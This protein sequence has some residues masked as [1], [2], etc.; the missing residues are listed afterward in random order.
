MSTA[1]KNY[2]KF[3]PKGEDSF[4]DAVKYRV[5]EY[6]R[7][8][9]ITEH[10][11]TAM[12]LKTVAMLSLYIV[13]YLLI[14]TGV[15]SVNTWLFMGLWVLMG[16]GIVGI[17]T[18]IMHDSN[19]GSYSTNKRLNTLLGN[20]L[21]MLGGYALNWRIQHNVLHHTY[22]NLQGLDEDIDSGILIRMSPQKEYRKFHRYQ[23]I[24]AW[25]LYPLMN[26]FWVT[27]KDFRQVMRYE[28]QGLLR[29]QKMTFGKAMR[30]LTMV[31]LVYFAYALVL[32]MIFS[33]MA[34]YMV[35]AGF[36]AMQMVAGLSLACI[37]QP[38]HVMETSDYAEP[39][40]K[41]KME[42]AWAVHQVLNTTDFCPKSKITSWF[43]G[44][45]NYQIEH[46]L[47]PHI[48]H[49]HYPKIAPI[50]RET[51]LEYGLPYNVVPTFLGALVEHGKMLKILGQEPVPAVI[52]STPAVVPE[53]VEAEY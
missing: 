51:V 25:L 29:N 36:V 22:T 34:W 8:N 10:A 52:S 14:V 19:H 30:Q 26:L 7:T 13:P 20:V 24:Y 5:Q 1:K 27:V 21:N 32:P 43:M 17:G 23:H 45:L 16:V 4:Y 42:N 3:A 48:C 6:F 11:N 2:V 41:R 37:F 53:L 46:H 33:G 15:G 39:D 44:G 12:R 40:D 50:V 18:G 35:L 9:N 38:A 31:K 28:E 47:F 49:I